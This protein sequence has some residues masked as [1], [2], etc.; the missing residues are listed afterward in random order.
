M[1]EL[2]QE[3]I[4]WSD[5]TTVVVQ[6]TAAAHELFEALCH[7]FVSAL[8]AESKV[9]IGLTLILT[10]VSGEVTILHLLTCGDVS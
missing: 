2:H 4:T 10:D 5:A 9:S 7:R 6:V 3:D 1:H 8:L